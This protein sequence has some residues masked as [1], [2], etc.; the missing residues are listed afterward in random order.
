M[1]WIDTIRNKPEAE[2]MRIIWTVVIVVALL[3]VV[4]WIFAYHFRKKTS[5]DTTLFQTIGRG[6]HDVKNNLGK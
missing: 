1:S 3:L 4:V 5:A 2:K 6:V